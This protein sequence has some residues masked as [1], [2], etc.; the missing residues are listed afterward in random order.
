MLMSPDMMGLNP[1]DNLHL[2]VALKPTADDEDGGHSLAQSKKKIQE[3]N[4]SR[5]RP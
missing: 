2:D 1:V 4:Q 3:M 5:P